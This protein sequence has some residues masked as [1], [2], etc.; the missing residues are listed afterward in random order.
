MRLRGRRYGLSAEPNVT[1]FEVQEDARLLLI[2]SDGACKMKD[3][4]GRQP[5]AFMVCVL[6]CC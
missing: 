2:A 5:F 3:I 6:V 1:Q 4:F